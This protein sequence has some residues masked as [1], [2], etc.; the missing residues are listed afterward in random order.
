VLF[1][2]DE[3]GHVIIGEAALSLAL[4]EKEISVYSLIDELGFMARMEA[5]DQRLVEIH[6]ARSWLKTM[7]TPEIAAQHVPYLHTLAGLNEQKN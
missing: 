4:S 7:D 2:E 5:S 1:P 3:I 6:E